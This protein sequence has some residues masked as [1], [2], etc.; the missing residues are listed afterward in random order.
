MSNTNNMGIDIDSVPEQ[1]ILPGIFVT[2][3]RQHN[4]SNTTINNNIN[5]NDINDTNDDLSIHQLDY[6]IY[7]LENSVKHLINSNNEMEKYIID[8]SELNNDN[9]LSNSIDENIIIIQRKQNDIIKLKQLRNKL[10]PQL[11]DKQD[12]NDNNAAATVTLAAS[13]TNTNTQQSNSN[14]HDNNNDT[15]NGL[16]L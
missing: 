1:E 4:T 9:I 11:T 12:S 10:Y 6:N 14:S 5:N 3:F 15:D 13:N 2:D 8:K 7:E 16:H